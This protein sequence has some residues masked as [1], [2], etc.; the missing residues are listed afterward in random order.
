MKK[1]FL[2]I[3]IVIL[4]IVCVTLSSCRALIYN[5]NDTIAINNL[6]TLVGFLEKRDKEEIKK[7]FAPNIANQIDEIDQQIEDLCAYY[8]GE[9][10]SF[11]FIGLHSS[12]PID[13]GKVIKYIESCYDI[14]TS[15]LNFHI[16]IQFYVRDDY[17]ENNVGIWSLFVES[18]INDSAWTTIEDWE[19]GIHL[20]EPRE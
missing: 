18:Y 7:M 5:D 6:K 19:I 11:S 4:S 12:G 15:S 8:S 3:G 17:D 20:R 2:T 14:Y 16:G 10:Q 1:M 9:Y 13:H